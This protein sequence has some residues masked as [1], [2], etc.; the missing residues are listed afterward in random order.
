MP[1][2]ARLIQFVIGLLLCFIAM[3]MIIPLV[4][5][6]ID[7]NKDWR[8]FLVSSGVT[9][10]FGGLLAAAGSSERTGNLTLKDGFMITTLCWVIVTVFC[11]I[12]FVGL[13]VPFT[14]AYF[15]AMSGLTTTGSTVLIQLDQ[16]P[17]GMLIWRALLNG[18]G[19]LGIIAMAVILLPFL[20]IG[21]MQLFQMESSDKS[22]KIAPRMTEVV[23][24]IAMVYVA[25]IALCAAIY[26]LLGMTGFDAICHALATLATGG[27]STHDASFGFFQSAPIEWVAIIFMALGALPFV[28]MIKVLRGNTDALWNDQQVRGFLVF[29]GGVSLGL[30]L[31]LVEFRGAYFWDALRRS[32]FNVISVV[33]TTG[34]ASED[35]TLWGPF[36]VGVFFLLTFVGGCAGSTAGGIKIYRLQIARILTRSYLL[37]LM[38]PHRVVPSTYNGRPVSEQASFSVVAFLTV[39]LFSTGIFTLLLAGTGLDMLTALSASAQA[40]SNVGPGLGDIVG[41][42]GNYAPL[43]TSAKWVLTSAMLLGRLELFTVLVLFRPEFWAR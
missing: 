14:D 39:Y 16:L 34:F 12:P 40:I 2:N 19:G 13:G 9:F 43:P 36:V 6:L 41:P 22:E 31:W 28:W 5:D 23:A 15:E 25:L 33:T 7:Q 42:A 30:A 8:V 32:A 27:F 24:A 29:V 10:F 18:L 17:R 35:Y 38:K 20:R 37:Q 11:A 3:A 26:W 1:F 21:G 4:V